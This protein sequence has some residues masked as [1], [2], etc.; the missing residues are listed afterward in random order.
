VLVLAE[1]GE[2]QNG[3]VMPAGLYSDDNPAPGDKAGL[4]RKQFGDDG[5]IEYDRDSGEFMVDAKG[6]ATLKVSDTTAVIEDGTITLKVSDTT[7]TVTDGKIALAV[8]GTKLEITSS[9]AVFTG[10][11]VKHDGK[12]ID[13]TH[14]H[15]GVTA[16]GGVSGPPQ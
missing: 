7:I 9:G 16:G 14:M 10:G 11:T 3:I 15:T 5:K 4:W 2:L 13:K 6:K 12:S 1:G 8:G